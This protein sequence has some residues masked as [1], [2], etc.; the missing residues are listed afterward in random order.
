MKIAGIQKLTLLDYPQKLAAIVFTPGC[1]FR[2]PFCH[3]ASLVFEEDPL[4]SM[5]TVEEFLQNRRGKLDGVVITG[6]EPLLQKDLRDFIRLVKEM[7]YLV[8]LDTNGSFP[9]KLENLIHSGHLDY[10][11]M[12]IKADKEGYGSLTGLSF[13]PM[14]KIE[15][16]IQLIRTC[17]IP[18]EFRTTMVKPLHTKES[19]LK[20]AEWIGG[21]NLYALQKFVQQD[22]LVSGKTFSAFTDEEAAEIA[23]GIQGAFG[24]CILRGYEE[25]SGSV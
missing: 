19:F 6:G 10:I 9:E 13:V 4:L 7:G 11:A 23:E 12:D 25:N 24:K 3:N 20:I 22:R 17:G 21:A 16:S 2:C 14:E 8:K 1:N 15:R 5:D 18:Y